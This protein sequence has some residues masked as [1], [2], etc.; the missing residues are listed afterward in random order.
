MSGFHLSAIIG[1]ELAR[2]MEDQLNEAKGD[3]L[4]KSGKGFRR[5]GDH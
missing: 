2:D 4:L 3:Q 5:L 1:V